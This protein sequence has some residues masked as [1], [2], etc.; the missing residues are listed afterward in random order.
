VPAPRRHG[1]LRDPRLDGSTVTAPPTRVVRSCPVPRRRRSH[2]RPCRLNMSSGRVRRLMRELVAGAAV[3]SRT[4]RR[5][6]S[7]SRSGAERGRSSA[8]LDPT[9]SRKPDARSWPLAGGQ[10]AG[11]EIDI[12]TALCQR[13]S[14]MTVSP[15]D[16]LRCRGRCARGLPQSVLHTPTA[17]SSEVRGLIRVVAGARRRRWARA[18]SATAGGKRRPRAD[19][20]VSAGGQ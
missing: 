1:A 9:S 16:G 6:L 5:P 4:C 3:D 19:G 7:G 14:T 8:K 12:H 15:P 11:P 10:A 18:R 2:R 17:G 13:P 20:V